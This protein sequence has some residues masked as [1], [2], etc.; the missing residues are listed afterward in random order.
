MLT[1]I[2][3]C[4]LVAPSVLCLFLMVPWVD[5]QCVIVVFPGH[6]H[7]LSDHH[8]DKGHGQFQAYLKSVLWL[9]TQTPLSMFDRVCS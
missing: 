7:F 1:L 4:C 2:A 6:T 9:E 3:F 8:Y 5:I